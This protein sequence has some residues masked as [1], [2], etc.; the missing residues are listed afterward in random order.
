VNGNCGYANGG[1]YQ[2]APK[3]G[4]CSSGSATVPY[5]SE[6]NWVWDCN[7]LNNGTD[8]SC[9]A[10][11]LPDPINGSCGSAQGGSYQS[12]PTTGLCSSGS[13][14]NPYLNGTNWIWNC[15]GSNGGTTASC[16]AFKTPD[17]VNGKCGSAN[18]GT[19]TTIPSWGLCS[20]GVAS[21]VIESDVKTYSWMCSGSNSGTDDFCTA[22]KKVINQRPTVDAGKDLE[23]EQGGRSVAISATATDPNDDPLTYAWKCNSGTLSSADTLETVFTSPDNVTYTTYY[24]CTITV[25][26]GNGGTAS[27]SVNIKVTA[28]KVEGVCG[29][30]NGQSVTEKPSIN[31]CTTGTPSLVTGSNPWNWT[32]SGLNGGT[33]STCSAYKTNNN[34]V[35]QMPSNKEVNEKQTILLRA[36]ATDADG[37]TL[38]YSWSCSGG[39]LSNSKIAMPYYTAPK[40]STNRIY[41]C[42]LTVSDKSGGTDTGTVNI[43]VRTYESGNNGIPVVNVSDDR[44]VKSGQTITLSNNTATDPDGDTLTYNWSCTGGNISNKNSLNPNYTAPNISST[45]T[46]TCTLRASDNK[47]GTGSDSLSITVRPTI[48]TK[49]TAPT[50]AVVK[51][52]EINPNQSLQLFAIAYDADGDTLSYNW[53]CNSGSL[54]DDTNYITTF[55]P[56]SGSTITTY[57]CTV[58]VSDSKTSTSATVRITVRTTNTVTTNYNPTVEAGNNKELNSGQSI[59]I[60]A[61]ASDP[62]GSYLS[63]NWTC[64]AGTLSNSNILNPTY[65][66]SYANSSYQ[67]TA[68]CTLTVRNEKGG[69]ATDSFTVTVRP[70]GE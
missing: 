1:S 28:A 27:D 66:A 42:T 22:T 70:E 11:K 24:T 38:V 15:N 52:R 58:K 10:T 8:A 51:D 67:T 59:I 5:L 9:S 55:T 57:T 7:G 32:C 37:D 46:Y 20:S 54:S 21:T 12:A 48:T 41:I 16:N 31:L 43:V 65:T 34:P 6:N 4:L 33:S 50:V 40:T 68:T 30:M 56:Y 2:S 63:Y 39:T 14:T 35:L 61:T 36:S 49:N 45:Q 62:N 29:N 64:S 60:N 19:Y 53:S 13:A 3:T 18:G 26:D 25:S 47:G 23:I 17:A 44:E 69:Y